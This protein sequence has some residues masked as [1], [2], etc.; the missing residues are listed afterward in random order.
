MSKYLGLSPSELYLQSDDKPLTDSSLFEIY[1]TLATKDSATERKLPGLLIASDACIDLAIRSECPDE[2]IDKS[3]QVLN[4]ITERMDQNF[5]SGDHKAIRKASQTVVNAYFR[6]AE[7][8]NWRNA[9]YGDEIEPNYG[10]VLNAGRLANRLCDEGSGGVRGRIIEFI[11][12]LL[13]SRATHKGLSET[14]SARTALQREDLAHGSR[15]RFNLN[16]DTGVSFNSTAD[17]Y[18]NPDLK[19]QIVKNKKKFQGKFGRAGIPILKA[20]RFNIDDP[21][22]IIN[23]CFNELGIKLA[24]IDS[25]VSKSTDELD[26]ITGNLYQ[27]FERLKNAVT[28]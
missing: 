7:L 23:G 19:I 3:D 17:G 5:E 9:I 2:W 25:S 10:L 27:E 24:N 11:P 22:S 8:H 1:S 15:S 13:G 21:K 26:D 18:I 4:R 6:Q 14:W 16:W 28:I 12:V 20:N